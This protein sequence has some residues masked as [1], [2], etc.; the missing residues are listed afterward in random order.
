MIARSR[1]TGNDPVAARE[2]EAMRSRA[3]DLE[4][5]LR[6]SAQEI[7]A[8]ERTLAADAGRD[9]GSGGP[10]P[11]LI[12]A[13]QAA[14][15]ARVQAILGMDVVPGLPLAEIVDCDHLTIV[16]DGLAASGLGIATGR[17]L[18]VTPAGATAGFDLRV[19]GGGGIDAGGRLSI[20]VDR[21]TLERAAG[22]TCPV[23]R[24]VALQI[25]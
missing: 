19:P 21:T 3:R 9:D 15:I 7:A 10:G 18:R 25:P 6:A 13:P 8:L 11:R 22:E 17:M 14:T 4:D 16:T 2:A 24:R 23:G 1:A 5:E 12:K 20:P